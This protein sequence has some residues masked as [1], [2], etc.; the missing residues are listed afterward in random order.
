MARENK[1][2]TQD[3]VDKAI[4]KNS[5]VNTD[6]SASF[7]NLQN[8]DVDYQVVGKDQEV[9]NH[10]LPWV[11]KFISNA[12]SW[13]IGAHHGIES[14]YLNQYLSEYVYRFN[15]CHDLDSLFF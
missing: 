3:F 6:G 7:V 11:H 2:E 8:I 10:W 9:F 4:E 5:M 1:K 12:K 14:K 15:R 13:I